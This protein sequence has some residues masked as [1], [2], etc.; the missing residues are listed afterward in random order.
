[1]LFFQGTTLKLYCSKVNKEC[2]HKCKIKFIVHGVVAEK[3]VSVDIAVIEDAAEQ[4][5]DEMCKSELR[6]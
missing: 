4:Y 3:E 1:M 5:L 2:K 6:G